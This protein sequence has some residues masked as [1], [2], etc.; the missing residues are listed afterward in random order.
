MKNHDEEWVSGKFILEILKSFGEDADWILSLFKKNSIPEIKDN[1]EYSISFCVRLIEIIKKYSGTNSVFKLGIETSKLYKVHSDY[2]KFISPH[3]IFPFLDYLYQMNV[4]TSEKRNYYFYEKK[5]DTQL[6]FRS[7]TPF[8]CEFEKGF[9]LGLF[10]YYFGVPFKNIEIE[11]L[12]VLACR[13]FGNLYCSYI[14][15]WK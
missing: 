12:P 7:G 3:D 11:H 15:S 1:K 10:N 9:L 13:N 14:I 4:K 2:N 8:Q 5:S 6:L